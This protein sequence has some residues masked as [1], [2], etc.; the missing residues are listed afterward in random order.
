MGAV[1]FRLASLNVVCK[2]NMDTFHYFTS[3]DLDEEVLNAF[4]EVYHFTLASINYHDVSLS[5]YS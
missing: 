3:T 1:H 4:A 2:E 5:V